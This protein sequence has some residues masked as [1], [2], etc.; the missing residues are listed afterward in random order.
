MATSTVRWAIGAMKDKTSIGLAKVS[1]SSISSEL[2]VAIIKA[3]SHDDEPPREKYIRHILSLTSCSRAYVA[4]AVLTLS[5]RISKTRDWIVALKSLILIHRLLA[6]GEPYFHHEI[7]H[8][9]RRGTCLLNLSYFRDES[10]SDS[11]DQSSFVRTFSLYLD[12]RLRCMIYELKQSSRGT[13]RPNSLPRCSESREV[14]DSRRPSSN[15]R[16]FESYRNSDSPLRYSNYKEFDNGDPNRKPCNSIGKESNKDLKLRPPYSNHREFNDGDLDRRSSNSNNRDFESYKER[17]SRETNSNYKNYT[18]FNFFSGRD[19]NWRSPNSN[20]GEFDSYGGNGGSYDSSGDFPHEQHQRRPMTPLRDMKVE[21]V[22]GRMHQLQLLLDRFLSCRPTGL[23]KNTRMVIIALYPVVKES[24]HL[25]ANICELLA[26]LL[27]HF[28]DME[29]SECVKTFEFYARAAE[30]INELIAFYSWCKETGV[31][32]SSE[33]PEVQRVSDEVLKTLEEFMKDPDRRRKNPKKETEK[34]VVAEQKEEPVPNETSIIKALP[35]PEN[36]N[37][38]NRVEN[39]SDIKQIQTQETEAD[40]L[41]LKDDTFSADDG[42]N[43]LALA[44]FSLGGPSPTDTQVTSAWQTPAAEIGKADWELVLVESASNLSNQKNTMARGLDPLL[45]NG[46]YDQGAVRQHVS[47]QLNTGGSASSVAVPRPNATP[48]LALPAP[49]GT[50][51]AV[52][53]DP[54]AASLSVPPPSYVQMAEMEKKQRLLVQEQQLWLQYARDGLQGQVS[55]AK[56]RGHGYYNAGP[57]M[58]MPYGMP[59]VYGGGPYYQSTI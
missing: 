51:Q 1:S 13:D 7:L 48:V 55:L 25:Y 45:L 9:T 31:M 52:G 15:Y 18:E 42:S 6:D 57:P 22:S 38:A 54:F 27:D 10:H 19:A 20:Y 8:A 3:T 26:V 34:D 36:C 58:A 47:A 50:V 53:Q 40:L 17:N 11:W 16:D 29:Y 2:D 49:D 46:M 59:S 12:Q 56:L 37:E 5:K 30:Q 43:R 44:L 33:Y 32:R 21:R 4:S 23:A 41:N 24:F 35:A 14:D 39:S 28:F